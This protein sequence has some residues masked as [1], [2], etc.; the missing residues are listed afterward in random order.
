MGVGFEEYFQQQK[1]ECGR[2]S[3]TLS[4]PCAARIPMRFRL[5]IRL[6]RQ[7]PTDAE[8]DHGS[9][10]SLALMLLYP[11]IFHPDYS[12]TSVA[13]ESLTRG[14][15]PS[16]AA[17]SRWRSRSDNPAAL[18]NHP[19]LVASLPIGARGYLP[20]VLPQII[21]PTFLSVLDISTSDDP[22]PRRKP[23]A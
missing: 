5:R 10:C 4:P 12:P 16:W 11:V 22:N 8:L 3:Q 9:Q 17:D 15:H 2:F 1:W 20:W 23:E 18:H 14:R 13:D 6:L 21:T 19:M 7:G